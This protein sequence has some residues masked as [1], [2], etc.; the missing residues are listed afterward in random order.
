LPLASARLAWSIAAISDESVELGVETGEEVAEL[1]ALAMRASVLGAS[2][3]APRVSSAFGGL[4][5]GK[6]EGDKVSVD[7][8]SGGNGVAGD[9]RARKAGALGGAGGDTVMLTVSGGGGR[10][11]AFAATTLPAPTAPTAIHFH[12][13]QRPSV[14]SAVADPAWVLAAAAAA[15]ARMARRC[16]PFGGRSS[17]AEARSLPLS[18][19]DPM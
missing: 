14:P 19:P 15:A 9:R 5:S 2:R 8:E 3:G 1:S 13:A 18:P 11:T 7:A 17:L 10:M 4:A 12:T 16:D 6:G